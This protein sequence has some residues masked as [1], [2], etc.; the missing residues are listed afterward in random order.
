METAIEAIYKKTKFMP[1]VSTCSGLNSVFS[2]RENVRIRQT[3][4]LA[5]N[6]LVLILICLGDKNWQ[7]EQKNQNNFIKEFLPKDH[8]PILL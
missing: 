3:S 7:K 4:S 2:W 5:L 8:N 1:S 6:A